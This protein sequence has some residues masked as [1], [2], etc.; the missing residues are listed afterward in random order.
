MNKNE[1]K[2][3]Y[4]LIGIFL[5]VIL[6]HFFNKYQTDDFTVLKKY[7][8]LEDSNEK[9]NK[10]KESIIVNL[11]ILLNKASQK[12]GQLSCQLNNDDV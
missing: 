7:A 3:I 12:V 6:V 2:W 10:E 9:S 1:L 5:T 4:L 11:S 8:S